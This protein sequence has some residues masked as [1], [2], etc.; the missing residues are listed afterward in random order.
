MAQESLS[1]EIGR[2]WRMERDGDT[3]GA[4]AE[5]ERILKKD[6]NS[7]DGLYGMGMA[8]RRAGNNASAHQAFAKA[9]ELVNAA[10]E[11]RNAVRGAHETATLEDDRNNMLARMIKQ[12]ISE[13]KG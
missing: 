8:Q 3:K 4:I 13:V 6:A 5:F 2:A 1:A 11:K 10:I 9:L 7:I 12:R